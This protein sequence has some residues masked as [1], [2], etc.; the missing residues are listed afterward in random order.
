[1]FSQGGA[2]DL[3]FDL[4]D[5]RVDF[6]GTLKQLYAGSPRRKTAPS[7]D[8][9]MAVQLRRLPITLRLT[10]IVA[11]SLAATALVLVLALRDYTAQIEAAR[12]DRV[13]TAVEAGQ[14]ILASYAK[15]AQAGEISVEAA[16][17]A[18][19]EAVRTVRYA[20]TEYLFVID[21]DDTVQVQP[22]VPTHVGKRMTD[23]KDVNG[24]HF[25]HD[26]SRVARDQG[27]G[28]VRYSW[29]KPGGD[30]PLPKIT[31]VKAV[32][33]WGWYVGSGAYVDDVA[34][35]IRAEMIKHGA[36]ALV[37]FAVA[38]LIS[39]LIGQ[40]L[41]R[42]LR[43]ITQSMRALAQGRLDTEISQDQGAELGEMQA[44]VAVFKDNALEVRRLTAAQ[45]DQ[46]RA[47]AAERTALMAG[48]ARSFEQK[49]EGIVGDLSKAAGHLTATAQ[50]M[51]TVTGDAADKTD[52]VAQA[53][54]RAS[55]NI[56]TVAAATEEL[57]SSIAEIA[58]QVN[59]SADIS[60][61]AVDAARQTDGIVRGLSEAARKIGDV[62]ALI[63]D[64]AS[65][66][67]LLALNATIEAARA[68]DAG[69]GF[70]VVANEVKTL[71]TQT[72]R[73]TE[74]IAAQ[75]A[76]VQNTS[77][78]AA[79]AIA[80]ISATISEISG[81]A[82]M[83]AAAVEQQGAATQEISRNT[84]E[85]ARGTREMSETVGEVARAVTAAGHSAAAVHRQADSLAGE[86]G[87]LHQAV[88]GFLAG[89][90]AG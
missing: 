49:V 76:E 87:S 26:M 41:T 71:A 67:N 9:T 48:L 18:A 5:G 33:E 1:M 2:Q 51:S 20:G 50:E 30:Q 68:G 72:G 70:A 74:E 78:Q 73:A 24:V 80:A 23:L 53:A 75:I 65:Q 22:A 43:Q 81:I 17:E 64:I 10:L 28:L 84:Q 60:S 83:I 44:A 16:K 90:R 31:Y 39:L 58:R 46:A 79:E 82:G 27:E 4:L 36:I 55:A 12:L 63:T 11:A 62:V 61:R 21:F 13:R 57:H 52:A 66:T 7:G 56:Q 54:E 69:K 38:V 86:A 59:Q 77:R 37:G 89:I 14:A 15:R 85:A 34:A 32:P 35:T 40:S 45:E 42:P 25:F 88:G 8:V 3:A 6:S 47:A 29:P 19:K